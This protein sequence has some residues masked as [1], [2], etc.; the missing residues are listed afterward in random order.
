[1]CFVDSRQLFGVNIYM[2]ISNQ[3]LRLNLSVPYACSEKTKSWKEEHKGSKFSSENKTVTKREIEN[4]IK[5]LRVNNRFPENWWWNDW[6]YI[7]FKHMEHLNIFVCL[8][9]GFHGSFQHRTAFYSG[10]TFQVIPSVLLAEMKGPFEIKG[11]F[12]GLGMILSQ[13]CNELKSP[14]YL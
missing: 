7:Y 8:P 2:K 13:Q 4:S 12:C 1:M 10:K 9:Q 14:F 11:L 6:I 5:H 3:R